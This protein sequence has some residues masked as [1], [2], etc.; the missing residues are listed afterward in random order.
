M[1][2]EKRAIYTIITSECNAHNWIDL[3]R[4]FYGK[5]TRL[6]QQSID[7]YTVVLV[8]YWFYTCDFCQWIC[9]SLLLSNVSL[10]QCVRVSNFTMGKSID[11]T[12]MCI[13]FNFYGM[14]AFFHMRLYFNFFSIWSQYFYC[15]SFRFL[16][17]FTIWMEL[18]VK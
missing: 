6:L 2:G 12:K 13:R 9:W 4:E 5:I 3:L 14:R 18:N 15:S 1:I 7:M 8:V 11:Y 17:M 16:R 10:L